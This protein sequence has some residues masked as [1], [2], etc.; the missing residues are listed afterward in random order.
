VTV[1]DRGQDKVFVGLD[2]GWSS[3]NESF[4][5]KIPYTPILCRA[6]DTEPAR[7]YTVAGHI[8]EGDDIFATDVAL[9]EVREGDIVAIPN[10]GAYNL[11]MASNHCLRPPIS[12]V[13]F[14]DRASN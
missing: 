6:A 11:S 3:L 1:E 10:V 9:P 13:S 7:T 14:T 2:A 5:Y 8:N 12:V 4:V